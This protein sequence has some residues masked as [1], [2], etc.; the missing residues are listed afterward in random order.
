MPL[1][2]SWFDDTSEKTTSKYSKEALDIAA[3]AVRNKRMTLSDA[4]RFYNVPKPTLYRRVN[5]LSGVKSCSRGRSIAIPFDVESRMASNI[6]VMEKWGYGL[7]KKEIISS[8]GQYLKENSIK[9]PFKD[10]I[11]GDGYFLNFKRRHHLSQKKPQAVEVARK[12]AADPFIISRYFELLH[13]VIRC[14]PPER[15]YNIDETSFCLDPSRVKVVGERGK[16]AHRVTAGPGRENVTVLMGGSASGQKLPPLIILK[17]KNFWNTWMADEGK[18]FPDTTY[19]ATENGWMNSDTF[20]NYFEKSFLP[21]IGKYRPAVLIYDGH[22]SHVSLDIIEK[23][24][25][26]NVIILKLPPHTSHLLQPMDLAV[27]KPLK[28][29]YDDAV[30]KWQRRNYGTKM[31]KNAFSNMISRIWTDCNPQ[32]IKSG[33]KKGG[34][35]PFDNDVISENNYDPA[36]LKRFKKAKQGPMLPQESSSTADLRADLPNIPATMPPDNAEQSTSS[37]T[38]FEA[39]LLA[40]VKQDPVRDKT[41]RRRVCNGAE[42]ITSS[43][44][45]EKLTKI[46]DDRKMKKK[47]VRK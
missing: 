13:D 20:A 40:H 27:F 8:M 22:V 26:E 32:L 33:F 24:V 11:P 16:A 1:I 21:A 43:Q 7:S 19:A 14:V 47:K 25:K 9:T 34:I 37:D 45:V 29:D 28:Q 23:A 18:G 36:A 17:G 10:N 44:A 5:G 46:E 42:V 6:K 12:R 39:M 41:K 4:S 3:N 31:S 35:Y 38:S 15:I 2:T 30:I